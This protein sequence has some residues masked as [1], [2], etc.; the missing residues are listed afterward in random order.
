MGAKLLTDAERRLV[1]VL[2]ETLL[3]AALEEV[4]RERVV[5]KRS[6]TAHTP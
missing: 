5:G 2:R 3:A 6:A 1:A 4:R